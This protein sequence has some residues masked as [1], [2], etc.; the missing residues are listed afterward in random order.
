MEVV[1]AGSA[2]PEFNARLGRWIA[3]Q[4]WGDDRQLSDAFLAFGVFDKDRR[5][6]A[7]IAYHNWSPDYGVI[8]FSGAA[9]NRRFITRDVLWQMSSYPFV[10]LGCQMAIARM[11]PDNAPLRRMLLAYG[12]KEMLIP[13]MRGRDKAELLMTLTDDDWRANGWHKD[14]H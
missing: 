1:W 4:I 5:L 2:E 6:A 12:F 11:D 8:E 3:A 10:E 9:T 13:R 14:Q 7:A